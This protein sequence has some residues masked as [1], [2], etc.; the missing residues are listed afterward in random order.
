MSEW[1]RYTSFTFKE[2]A[3]R[4]VRDLERYGYQ[5]KIEKTSST[6]RY[7]DGSVG[8][9]NLYVIYIKSTP[10]SKYFNPEVEEILGTVYS[11]KF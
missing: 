3:L 7:Y 1:K 2:Q 8:T 5:A 11:G 4:L 9:S 6:H 10:K